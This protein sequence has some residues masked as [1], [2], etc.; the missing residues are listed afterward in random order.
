MNVCTYI[1]DIILKLIRNYMT[2]GETGNSGN[3]LYQNK[4]FFREEFKE[5]GV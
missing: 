2:H 4:I 5:V 1:F 3:T